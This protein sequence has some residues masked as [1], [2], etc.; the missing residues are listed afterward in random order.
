MYYIPTQKCPAF[1]MAYQ[2]SSEPESIR[3]YL[4][5]APEKVDDAQVIEKLK[6]LIWEMETYTPR[7]HYLSNFNKMESE[8][9]EDFISKLKIFT[10]GDI[11]EAAQT[12][13]EQW[14]EKM[15]FV[16]LAP[17]DGVTP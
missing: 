9:K 1:V 11:V 14:P 5:V 16:E 12:F 13:G 8:L 4:E 2:S 17:R 3:I 6:A 10:T 15:G 7:G